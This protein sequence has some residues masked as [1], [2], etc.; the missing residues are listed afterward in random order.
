MQGIITIVRCSQ[1]QGWVNLKQNHYSR[2]ITP[3]CLPSVYLTSL[4]VTKSPRPSPSIFVYC[5]QSKTGGGNDLGTRVVYD[6]TILKHTT[7]LLWFLIVLRMPAVPSV[8]EVI[9]WVITTSVYGVQG[10]NSAKETRH[11]ETC[12][13]W[14]YHTYSTHNACSERLPGQTMQL[15][16]RQK[17]WEAVGQVF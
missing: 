3:M 11:S 7:V 5:K 12:K 6:K 10:Q 1:Q 2:H 4:H 8:M 15:T 14:M 17:L 9:V 16:A 13:H